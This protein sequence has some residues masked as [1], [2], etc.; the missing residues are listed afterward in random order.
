MSERLA[1]QKPKRYLKALL[2]STILKSKTKFDLIRNRYSFLIALQRT[3]KLEVKPSNQSVQPY[4]AWLSSHLWTSQHLQTSSSYINPPFDANNC[5][6]CIHFDMY[7]CK[8]QYLQLSPLYTHT[9]I[10][11]HRRTH[12]PPKQTYY[13]TIK[14]IAVKHMFTF[15]IC[16]V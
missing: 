11:T 5:T 6:K 13:K 14:L 15:I 12:R 8:I 10:H 7:V 4:L 3:S 16:N 9:H 2:S 1:V